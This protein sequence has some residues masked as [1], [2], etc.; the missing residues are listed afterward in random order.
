VIYSANGGTICLN[1]DGSE[2][3]RLDVNGGTHS[4]WIVVADVNGDHELDVVVQQGGRRARF[5]A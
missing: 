2:R 3:W 5:T 4:D 1:R